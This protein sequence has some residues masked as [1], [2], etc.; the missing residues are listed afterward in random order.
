MEE[1]LQAGWKVDSVFRAPE[2]AIVTGSIPRFH[3]SARLLQSVS[4]LEHSTGILALARKRL[5]PID[6]IRLNGCALLLDGL[7][8]PGNI[9]TLLRSAAAFGIS[10]VLSTPGTTHLYNPKIVRAAM[11]AM[12]HL[13]LSEE[14]DPEGLQLFLRKKR[15]Q[16]FCADSRSGQDPSRLDGPARWVIAVGHETTGVSPQL[17]ALASKLIRIPTVP[18]VDSLNA[19]VAGSILLYLFTRMGDGRPAQGGA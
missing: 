5:V 3:I 14:V 19:G 7:Q 12:F 16:L 8:D 4:L 9:G 1:A 10:A 17:K 2:H 11:G 6:Q 18:A 15:A 13:Q